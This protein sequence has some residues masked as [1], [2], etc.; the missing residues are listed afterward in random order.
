ML[1]AALRFK[2]DNPL[3][4]ADGGPCRAVAPRAPGHTAEDPG[5]PNGGICGREPRDRLKRC[6]SVEDFERRPVT[7]RR[8]KSAPIVAAIDITDRGSAV[9]T[10]P[11][12]K[13][14]LGHSFFNAEKNDL[15][16]ALP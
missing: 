9:L 11:V 5:I 1:D 10:R 13:Y 14:R 8:M 15:A 12:K 3:E 6:V 4:E 16:M 7:N 2:I